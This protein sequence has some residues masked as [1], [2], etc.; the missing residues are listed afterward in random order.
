[1]QHEHVLAGQALAG[2]QLRVQVSV[3]AGDTI[4][5]SGGTIPANC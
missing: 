3:K 4:I 2:G 5:V 1:V